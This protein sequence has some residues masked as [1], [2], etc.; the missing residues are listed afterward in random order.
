[1]NSLYY[2]SYTKDQEKSILEEKPQLKEKISNAGII[3]KI[4]YF[5]DKKQFLK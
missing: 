4:D 2:N 1:M 5:N 3:K